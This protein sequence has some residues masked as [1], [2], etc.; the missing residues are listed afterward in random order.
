MEVLID[1]S[2]WVDYFRSGK[3]SAD[4]DNL[5]DNNLIVTNDIILAELIPFL[6]L[7][8]QAK[9][10]KLL[11]NVKLLP[12]NIN[13]AQII[14]FQTMSL[15]SGTNGIGIP[16]LIITQNALQNNCPVYTLDKHF[17]ALSKITKVKIYN[18]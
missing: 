16:D 4:L 18:R 5:I 6:K 7:K 1:S 11:Q 12:L 13:W 3:H 8:K 9:T 17:D 2:I 15:K 14:D 10:I